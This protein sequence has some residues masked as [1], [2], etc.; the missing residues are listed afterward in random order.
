MELLLC[1]MER[2]HPCVLLGLD[3]GLEA[4]CHG[5][6]APSGCLKVF[7]LVPKASAFLKAPAVSASPPQEYLKF[8][9]STW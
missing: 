1:M 2:P 8:G 7:C 6:S 4:P 5:S 9:V 3:V